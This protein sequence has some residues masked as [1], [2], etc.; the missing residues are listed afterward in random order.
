MQHVNS[1]YQQHRPYYEA[2]REHHYQ[3]PPIP[4]GVTSYGTCLSNQI[5][6]I[7]GDEIRYSERS[8]SLSGNRIDPYESYR[9]SD[10]CNISNSLVHLHGPNTVQSS[11]MGNARASTFTNSTISGQISHVACQ[12]TDWQAPRLPFPPGPPSSIYGMGN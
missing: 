3:N 12:Q 9:V 4:R 11:P 1:T 5:N 10:V 2:Y 6:S 8:G 7:P